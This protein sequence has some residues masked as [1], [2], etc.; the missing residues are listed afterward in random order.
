MKM[1]PK[2]AVVIIFEKDTYDTF[3]R[4]MYF[5][6][7]NDAWDVMHAFGRS[8]KRAMMAVCEQ[9]GPGEKPTDMPAIQ[10]RLF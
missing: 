7:H 3:T 5:T 4:A 2:P 9:Y 6:D 10:E 1:E 8:G